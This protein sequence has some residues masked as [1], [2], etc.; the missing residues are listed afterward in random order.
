MKFSLY[1]ALVIISNIILNAYQASLTIIRRNL[2]QVCVCIVCVAGG[3]MVV[4]FLKA[5][6][7]DFKNIPLFLILK[8]NK[9]F[10]V[11]TPVTWLTRSL[12]FSFLNSGCPPISHGQSRVKIYQDILDILELL[13]ASWMAWHI[14][15]IVFRFRCTVYCCMLLYTLMIWYDVMKYNV[16]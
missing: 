3:L 2:L 16:M 5:L 6:R 4:S 13:E 8:I 12:L 14:T 9:L 15:Y 10:W 11:L 7:I 1:Y